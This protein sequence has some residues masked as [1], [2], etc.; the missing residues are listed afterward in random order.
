MIYSISNLKA[1]GGILNRGYITQRG[2]NKNK[3]RIVVSAGKDLETGKRIQKT[4]TFEG[5]KKDANIFLTEKLQE[6]DKG[7]FCI[8]KNM[9][10]SDYINY[11]LEQHCKLNLKQTTC[12]GYLQKIKNDIIP[13]LGNIKLQDLTP[14]Q[15]QSFYSLKLQNGLSKKNS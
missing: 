12:I 14:I 4:Y 7:I 8:S 1:E 11:W 15:L 9:P 2:K 5:T 3:W 6:I 13:I 10:F